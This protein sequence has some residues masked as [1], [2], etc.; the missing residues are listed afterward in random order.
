ML[1][2]TSVF[3]LVVSVSGLPAVAHALVVSAASEHI[4]VAH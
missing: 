1:T 3:A 2:N 4:A